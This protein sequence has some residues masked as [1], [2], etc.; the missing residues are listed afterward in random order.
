LVETEKP[1]DHARHADGDR[2]SGPAAGKPGSDES[3]SNVPKPLAW[4]G[5]FHPPLTHFPIA[6]LITAATA[7]ILLIRRGDALFGHSTQFCVW[8]GASS[9]VAAA[10]LGWL[11]AGFRLVD[12]EW[13]MT[14]HRWAGTSTG[15]LSV[16]LLLLGERVRTG[17]DSRA[18]FRV[19]LFLAAVLVGATGF[20]GGSLIYGLDHFNW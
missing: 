7:E 18:M 2:M 13:V 5:K 9:A 19:V 12:D 17:V 20:L 14:A 4:L 15:L 11:F 16:G 6:L 3:R 8:I 10:L 1:H